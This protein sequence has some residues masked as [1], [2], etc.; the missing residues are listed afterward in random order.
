MRRLFPRSIGGRMLALSAGATLLA[1]ALAGFFM[2]GILER[3]VTLGIDQRLD[4]QISLLASSVDEGGRIDQAR[5]ARLE[6]I[7]DAGRGWRWRIDAPRQSLGADDFPKVDHRPDE[8][9][10]DDHRRPQNP[11]PSTL[12]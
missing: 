10:H 8:R 6:G 4:A 11:R 9:E 12:R 5:L 1:L 7:L 3:F 2:T